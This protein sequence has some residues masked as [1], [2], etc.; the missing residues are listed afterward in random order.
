MDSVRAGLRSGELERD[1][2]DRL[3]CASCG[4]QLK[5]RDDPDEIFDVRRCPECGAA[6]KQL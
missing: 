2:Y 1:T 5:R 4:T 3:V 6:Y